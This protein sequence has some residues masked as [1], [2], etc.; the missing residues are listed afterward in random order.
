MGIKDGADPGSGHPGDPACCIG[1]LPP[2]PPQMG[3]KG[4]Q[5]QG[6][7]AYNPIYVSPSFPQG[8]LLADDWALVKPA[9]A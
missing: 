5:R 4:T 3:R 8:L 2:A 7:A 9:L 6:Q 1:R